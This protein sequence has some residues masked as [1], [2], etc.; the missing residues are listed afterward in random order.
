V[1][2]PEMALPPAPITP[3]IANC[4]APENVRSESRLVWRSENPAAILAAPK[5]VP[6]KPTVKETLR[7]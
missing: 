5:A 6:Y 7:L 2:I 3:T 1:A 4:D